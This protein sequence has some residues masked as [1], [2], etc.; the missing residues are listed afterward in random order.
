MKITTL[1]KWTLRLV[2]VV[3]ALLLSGGSLLPFF[4]VVA[5]SSFNPEAQGTLTPRAFLPLVM[6]NYC[7]G[8]KCWSGVHLGN[9]IDDW[10]ATLLQ[11]IDPALGGTWPRAVVIL[12]N[13]VY[14]IN[15]YSS[16]HPIYP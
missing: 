7:D 10:N 9:R 15:R 13:L 4:P 2:V 1:I 3:V 11:R 16:V 8:I 14:Q 12:S 5:E 6:R